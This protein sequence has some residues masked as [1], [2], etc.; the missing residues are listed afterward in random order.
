MKSYHFIILIILIISSISNASAKDISPILL[1]GDKKLPPIEYLDA[2]GNPN[3]FVVDLVKELSKEIGIPIEIRLTSWNDAISSLEKGEVDGCQFMRITEEREKLFDFIPIIENFSVIVV[4]EG[5]T[6]E[7]FSYLRGEK[8]A[9]EKGDVSYDFLKEISDVTVKET[10]EDV[11]RAVLDKEVSGGV[12][13]YYSARWM[14]MENNWQDRLLILPDKLFTN[15]NGIALR[16]G[17]EYLPILEEGM[18][19]LK[20]KGIY[21]SLLIKWLGE[22]P[23][24]RERLA[25]EE[26]VSLIILIIAVLLVVLTIV[27]FLLRGY[28]KREVDRQTLRIRLLLKGE[29]DRYGELKTIYDFLHKSASVVDLKQLGDLFLESVRAI[30]PGREIKIFR[31]TDNSYQ[32]WIAH[33]LEE[34]YSIMEDRIDVKYFIKP[35]GEIFGFL[36]VTPDIPK[37]NKAAIDILI[38][39]FEY[40]ITREEDRE[41]LLRMQNLYSLVEEFSQLESR[42]EREIILK[43]VLRRIVFIVRAEAGSIMILN[44]DDNKLYIK[45]SIGLPYELEKEVVLE[46]G[47]G[48]AGWVAL[49]KIPLILEDTT[50][51]P[52][53]KTSPDTPESDIKSSVCLPIIHR[54]KVIGVLNLNTIKEYRKF[55]ERD[56]EIINKVIPILADIIETGLLEERIDLLN[57]EIL[58]SLVEAI[59]MRDPY[60]R[61]HS[62]EVAELATLLGKALN[63]SR[64]DLRLLEIAGYIHDIGKLKIP[65]RILMKPEKLNDEE[66]EIMK[67]H[68]VWGF[69][70][71]GKI[72]ALIG[73][74]KIVRHHHERWDGNGYPD[75]LKGEEIPFLSRVLAL[76]DS[77][78]A[79]T[80]DRP[81]RNALTIPGAIEELRRERDRQFDGRLVDVFIDSVIPVVS[82]KLE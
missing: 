16:K 8:V 53:Y 75:G 71:L 4:P 5:S 63:L 50:R 28:L 41:E 2:E 12:V 61:G 46:L 49:N 6:I 70:M 48:I 22:E 79:M 69:E 24:I 27:L 18:S 37:E 19:I 62:E 67:L 15:Y 47:E 44:S 52:R 60:T 11:L 68:P 1:A 80:S 38:K 30:I 73:I 26:K 21:N 23:E 9:C 82:K 39:E 17:S 66:W 34:S 58:I 14:I 74:D 33:P 59:E 77:F 43:D 40:I 57:R 65:D 29:R 31:K 56:I 13:G 42:S 55:D 72:T 78:Q 81:Y 45:A 10:Q 25:R 32:L 51:D 3:G 35:K 20:E 76:A 64:E 36:T 7:N 54:D